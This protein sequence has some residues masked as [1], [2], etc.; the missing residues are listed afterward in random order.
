[1]GPIEGFRFKADIVDE[2]NA[3]TGAQAGGNGGGGKG[4]GKRKRR[5]KQAAPQT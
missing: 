5:K 2:A 3:L 4:K 1:M